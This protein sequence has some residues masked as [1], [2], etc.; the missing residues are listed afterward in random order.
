MIRARWILT[1]ISLVPIVA[2][3]AFGDIPGTTDLRL[4]PFPKQVSIRGGRLDIRQGM[5]IA[6]SDG[7]AARQSA[8]DLQSEIAR[9]MGV[10]CRIETVSATSPWTLTLGKGSAI[11]LA[12]TPAQNE[13]YALFVRR[14][15]A[16]V[17]A[18]TEAGLVW[19]IQALKQLVRANN[20]GSTIPCLTIADYPSIRYRGYQDDMTRGPSPKLPTLK[21]EVDMTALLRMNFFTYYIEHQFDYK[22]HPDI[23][24]VDGR[25]EPEE[26]KALM[27]YAEQRG[28]EI[29]GCQQSFGHLTGILQ[30]DAY[31]SLR[32]TLFTICPTNEDTYKLLDDL[33]SEQAPILKSKLFNICC[34]ETFD[35]GTGPSK[36]LAD[37]IGVGGVYVKHIRR[38]HDILTEKYGK[39]MMMWGDIILQHPEN[40]SEIPKDTIMLSWGYDPRDSF[41]PAIIPFAKSGYEFFVC[42]G[43]N[44]WGRILPDFNAATVNIRN[45]VRDGAKHGALGVLNTTW[46]DD[47]ENL[48]AYNWHGIAWG[49]ECSWNAST[50][51]I[52]DFN[53][54]IGA[55]IF[56]EKGDHYGRAIELLSKTHSLPGYDG[57]MNRRFLNGDF[58]QLPT[59]VEDSR[60]QAKSLLALVDPALVELRACRK[61]AT[62]NLDVLDTMI[63]G[64]ERMRLMATRLLDYI[65]A[66]ETY[67]EAYRHVGFPVVS[68]PGPARLVEKTIGIITRIRDEH[69]VMKRRY[70][71]IY[72]SSNKPYA[73]DWIQARYDSLIDRYNRTLASLKQAMETLRQSDRLPSAQ[74]VGI[75]ITESGVRTTRPSSISASPLG[76]DVPWLAPGFR[77]RVGITIKAGDISR[78]DLPIQ[79]DVTAIGASGEVRLMKDTAAVQNPIPAQVDS[80]GN[81]KILSFIVPGGM[82]PGSSGSRY[83]YYDPAGK[84]TKITPPGSSSCSAGPNGMVWLEND[85]IRL[86]V[87]PEGGH[88]YRWE[89]R[90]LADRDF[91]EPGDKDWQGFADISNGPARNAKNRVE[92]LASGPALARVRCTDP[93]GLVKTISLWAGMPWAEVTLNSPTSWFWCY[94]DIGL[95]GIDSK[96]PGSYQFSN[97]DTGKVQKTSSTPDCQAQRGGVHWSAK[98]VAGGPMLAL[99]TPEIATTHTVGPGSGM[100]GVGLDAGPTAAHFVIYGELAPESPADYLNAL[101][102]TLDFRAQPGTVVYAVEHR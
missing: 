59:S 54:R 13:G 8:R 49:A 88:I 96:T 81:R 47:A 15:S 2:G 74:E 77:K 38:V 11:D 21:Q 78:R 64:A 16:G 95:M 66:G 37:K 90:A 20:E 28:V 23:A 70:S 75:D 80:V 48:F 61:E 4:I 84:T 42:P 12:Q 34:D 62:A 10:S 50:T 72:L 32:E 18:R 14:E 56:G 27:D 91:T 55:V 68:G 36:P 97:G 63:F 24:P 93:S 53:R 45:Y 17:G 31:K 25:F 1:L 99:L 52:G 76:Q 73:L 92:I 82:A 40:L 98:Y 51:P 33:Y 39:R 65:E 57:M 102:A 71:T 86:L 89:V 26:L 58:G 29:V 60:R 67:S 3:Q 85:K 35:L 87:G 100:G 46:L 5:T 69:L 22:K 94:D 6:V 44:C 43:V 41:E 7:V 83:L 19:G 101:C 9:V 79:V 30:L